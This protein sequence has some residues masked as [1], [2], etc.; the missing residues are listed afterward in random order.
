MPL[1]SLYPSQ[2]KASSSRRRI[3]HHEPQ[4]VSQLAR[5]YPLLA[6]DN[7]QGDATQGANGFLERRRFVRR[8]KK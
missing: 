7:V 3:G 6:E 2:P 8:S 5:P 1:R 4:L